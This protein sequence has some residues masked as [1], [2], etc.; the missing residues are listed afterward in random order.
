[1]SNLW[2]IWIVAALIFSLLEMVSPSFG[3]IFASASAVVAALVSL[4]W[5]PIEQLVSFS[6]V[7]IA[8]L[9]TVRPRLIAKLHSQNEIPTRSQ[10]LLGM[11]GK[12]THEID[13]ATETGRVTVNG[14]D[15]AAQ[16]PVVIAVGATITVVEA[17]GIV[18]KVKEV[19]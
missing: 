8:F 1:M 3:F 2:V 9:F 7:V 15:W 4:R 17:D 16:S 10:A 13:P 12:V 6:V 14:E 11:H 19:L 5:G 18:L